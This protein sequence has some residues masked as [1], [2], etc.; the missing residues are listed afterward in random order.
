MHV[1]ELRPKVFPKYD[2]IGVY[3]PPE[4]VI[5]FVKAIEEG[6]YIHRDLCATD[7][8]RMTA[9]N[10]ERYIKE[11]IPVGGNL[12][13]SYEPINKT[14]YPMIAAVNR[15]YEN[16]PKYNGRIIH[17]TYT[18]P[19]KDDVNETL[20]FVG[21]G[22][23]FDSGGYSLKTNGAMQFMRKDKCGATAIV[24]FMRALDILKPKGLKVNAKLAFV[25]NG[26]GD[27]AY[28]VDE[29]IPTA[30]GIRSRIGSTDAEGRNVMV[31]L[32]VYSKMEALEATNPHLFTIA[33]LTGHVSLA[34]GHIPAAMDNGPARRLGYAKALSQGGAL[35]GDPIEV[36]SLRREDYE[37]CFPVSEYED[38]Q[39]RNTHP[40]TVK[41]RGHQYPAA[42]MLLASGMTDYGMQ[43]DKISLPYTHMDVSNAVGVKN[44]PATGTPVSMLVSTYVLP[45]LMEKKPYEKPIKY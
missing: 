12:E 16:I 15:L 41:Y 35:V 2:K 7:E 24:G 31:D 28:L 5:D 20:F 4:K 30:A 45:R 23:T 8:E 38:L 9:A 25:R 17:M 42:W 19:N 40:E 14:K 33:T 44:S 32:L 37:V 11:N 6:R 10:V 21:K 22:I 3:E 39:Q 26:I 18:P 29:I 43:N 27:D 36:S 1:R 34:F 13:I